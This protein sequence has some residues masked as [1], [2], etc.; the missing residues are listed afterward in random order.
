MYT[1]TT[2]MTTDEMECVKT[3]L[4]VIVLKRRLEMKLG[5]TKKQKVPSSIVASLK[6]VTGETLFYRNTEQD[7]ADENALVQQP[8]TDDATM[9]IRQLPLVLLQ[10]QH[11]QKADPNNSTNRTD[12]QD[13]NDTAASWMVHLQNIIQRAIQQ[14]SKNRDNHHHQYRGLAVHVACQIQQLLTAAAAAPS[15]QQLIE[16]FLKQQM[17]NATKNDHYSLLPSSLEIW[18]KIIETKPA[19][20]PDLMVPILIQQLTTTTTHCRTEQPDHHAAIIFAIL[21][22]EHACAVVVA[23]PINQTIRDRMALHIQ[24][25]IL[26]G[27]ASTTTTTT[28]GGSTGWLHTMDLATEYS[29]A[30]SSEPFWIVHALEDLVE[31]ITI[32]GGG[33]GG[34]SKAV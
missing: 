12:H 21:L 14:H 13:D 9:A 30:A 2:A 6:N 32:M 1:T 33:G 31:R 3:A 10:Q 25:G 28:T 27:V 15:N 7:T 22:L 17:D 8:E 26:G 19:L 29:T 24:N 23:T 34:S 20:L 5:T 16:T 11:Q 18:K 4:S